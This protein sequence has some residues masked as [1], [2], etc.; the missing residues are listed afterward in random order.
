[1]EY[2]VCGLTL[3]PV[4]GFHSH[5]SEIVTQL[6][7]GE[8]FKILDK[9]SK[10][11]LIESYYDNYRGWVDE[12]QI[13]QISKSNYDSINENSKIFSIEIVR[14]ARSISQE[15]PILMGSPLPF[16]RNK[17]FSLFDN[18]FAF[19]GDVVNILKGPPTG[20]KIKATA[21]K[22]LNAPYLWGG[23]TPL[24]IDCSG[25][26]QMVYKLN[27]IK[28]PRDSADQSKL[29]DKINS[30]NEAQTGD[31]AFF[32]NEIQAITHVGIMLNNAQVIHA[33][34]K[35]RIDSINKSGIYNNE[36]GMESHK[37]SFIRR[38]Y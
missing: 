8:T 16:Y 19:Q 37:F 24:G 22:F 15:Y 11:N 33:H 12:K 14:T 5:K 25:F 18:K 9:R 27:G 38:I 23:R 2:G 26:S 4:R 10:W 36:L 31:L 6:L 34:G 3:I 30:I 7:F 13:I 1:M 35:V 29:G 17:Q 28:I 20:E 21:M 32:E